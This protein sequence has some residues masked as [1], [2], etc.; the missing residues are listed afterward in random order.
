MK[1]GT[2]I[3]ANHGNWI[4]PRSKWFP[5]VART[6]TDFSELRSMNSWVLESA[7]S[8]PRAITISR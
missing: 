3:G 5:S 8:F 1:A 2:P 6:S 7:M 4:H